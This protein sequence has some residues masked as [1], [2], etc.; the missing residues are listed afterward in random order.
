[1]PPTYSTTGLPDVIGQDYESYRVFRTLRTPLDT[2]PDQTAAMTGGNVLWTFKL[3]WQYLSQTV[4]EQLLHAYEF[5]GG[6]TGGMN[7]FEWV[8]QTWTSIYVGKG[9]ASTT[10][11]DLPV[12]GAADA[13][14]IV[15]VGG[16]TTSRAFTAA[17]GP[18]GEDRISIIPAP[19]N[20]A[21]IR[22]SFFGRRRR[23]VRV[24][25]FKLAARQGS[26]SL[27]TASLDLVETEGTGS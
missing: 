14:A 15:T 11:F 26:S 9:N 25:S 2:F 19:A 22:A 17:A 13:T 16:V 10:I 27:W 23:R 20:N 3:G 21:E 4:A 12:K 6:S 18:D 8:P 24:T 7:W 5:L 1:M